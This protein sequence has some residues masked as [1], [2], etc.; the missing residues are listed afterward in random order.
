MS[1]WQKDFIKSV[2]TELD[3]GNFKINITD[4]CLDLKVNSKSYQIILG[5]QFNIDSIDYYYGYFDFYDFAP[6]LRDMLN[7]SITKAL[8]ID[9]LANGI[10]L[11]QLVDKFVDVELLNLLK[12]ISVPFDIY[13]PLQALRPVTVISAM[14]CTS[15]KA[16]LKLIL[17]YSA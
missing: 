2:I 3:K 13:K 17:S 14:S 5:G 15:E 16:L 11:N 4:R 8:N 7:K 6:H 1:D 9:L 10:S 12:L